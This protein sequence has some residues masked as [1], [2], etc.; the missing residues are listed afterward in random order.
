MLTLLAALVGTPGLADTA[1]LT[2]AAP[3]I[4][5]TLNNGG[6]FAPGG[7][8]NVRVETNDDGYLIVFRVDGDG[9]IRVLFPLDPDG[10]AFIRGGKEYELRG[11]G[12]RSTFLADDH[13]GNGMI[14]AALAHQSYN[15][16]DF[17]ANGHWD[18]DALRLR[19]STNDAENDL[20]AIVARMTSHGR[21]DYDAIGYRVQDIAS[22]V[23]YSTPIGGYYTG[24]YDPYYNPR[25]RCLSCGWGYP[26]AEFNV[27]FGYSPFWDPWLY[28][29]WGYN[30]GNGFGYGYTGHNWWYGG[31]PFYPVATYPVPQ[32][33]TG[34]RS[35]PR[36]EPPP[37]TVTN[38][39]GSSRN[40]GGDP[41]RNRGTT[42]APPPPA[43]TPGTRA[44]P[45]PGDM[46]VINTLGPTTTSGHRSASPSVRP[47]FRQ[48]QPDQVAVPR[49]EQPSSRPVY[50][51][52][53][54]VYRAPP[55]QN[56][57]S[58]SA[59]RAAPQSQP[60]SRSAPPPASTSSRP[61][62]GGR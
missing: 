8:V 33:P 60:A 13:G 22:S 52:P 58:R 45:R 40:T 48:P 57:V 15:V 23:G 32:V 53:Q 3:V 39:N 36:P 28:S 24:L 21:F 41:T 26:G 61:R 14:Y 62:G 16:R 37:Q 2:A 7:L 55:P 56:T 34:T 10:D 29:P 4:Q 49:P 17:S 30:Y 43:A 59:P 31:N 9:R 35:R 12:E 6:S 42:S 46:A 19:D 51:E 54:P 18:Y 50:R 38:V 25:W 27:G 1:R 11:R 20:N 44:R 5:V 47:V